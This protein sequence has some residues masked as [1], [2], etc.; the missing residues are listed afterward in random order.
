LLHS[1]KNKLDK[2]DKNYWSVIEQEHIEASEYM[3]ELKERLRII[4]KEIIS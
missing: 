1:D 4:I 2:D 3:D